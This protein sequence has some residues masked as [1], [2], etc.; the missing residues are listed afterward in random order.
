[1][2]GASNFRGRY[3][4]PLSED[5]VG[6]LGPILA[7]ETGL[8]LVEGCATDRAQ[9]RLPVLDPEGERA[10]IF[11][12]SAP[13]FSSDG[14]A[15]MLVHILAGGLYGLGESCTVSR[16]SDGTWTLGGCVVLFQN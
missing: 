13:V 4:T 7:A 15:R 5:L 10:V 6:T 9:S 8:L 1:M 12:L 14:E 16:S 2:A 11:L 3:T